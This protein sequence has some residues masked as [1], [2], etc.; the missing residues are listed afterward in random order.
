MNRAV[1]VMRMHL[2]DRVTLFV[3]P[4]TI[5]A[6]A[7]AI[8]L[9]LWQVVPADG[10]ST[11]GGA[12]VY[13]FVLVAAMLAVVRGLPFAL[14]MGSSRR[15][16]TIGTGLVGLVIAVAF[17][18][19]YL[20]LQAVEQVSDGWGMRG[21]FFDFPWF[22]GSSWAIRWLLFV[23]SFATT[24]LLG[25]WVSATW[26]RWGTLALVV[27]APLL[28]LLG[29]GGAVLV[30]WQRWWGD[31]WS[32]F[33]DLTPLTLTGWAT[34]LAVVLGAATWATLRRVRAS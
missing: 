14:G 17:G 3:M 15:A 5:L 28:I 30:S 7:F 26:A 22:D 18:T 8:N 2:V 13:F 25:A 16:F 34:L 6:A 24:F 4:L 32:W 9:A 31:V 12:S 1:A 29:G 21:R 20:V 19:L 27:G 10:R 23:V 33:G 11:G